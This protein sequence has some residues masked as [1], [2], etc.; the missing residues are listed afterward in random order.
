MIWSK[1]VSVL[2]VGFSTNKKKW[3]P[4]RH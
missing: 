4:D 2:T 3:Y 1:S